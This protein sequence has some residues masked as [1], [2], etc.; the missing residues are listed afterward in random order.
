MLTARMLVAI[1]GLSSAEEAVE[2]VLAA[3]SAAS[4]PFGVRF[5][6]DGRFEGDF[7]DLRQSGGVL[8]HG[9]VL[10]FDERA[11]LR[12][13]QPLLTDETHFLT[14]LGPYGFA[15]KWDGTL[16]ARLRKSSER[17]ALMTGMISA[18][19]EGLPPEPYLP[20]F[21]ENFE[22]DGVLIERG[23]PL[24]CSAAPVRTLAVDPAL[25]FGPTEFLRCADPETD[26]LSIAAYMAGFPVYALDRPALWPL[27][28]APARRLR[29][30]VENALPGTTLARFEQMAGFR[31]EQKRA[32][33][34]TT[35]G[36][37]TVENT[38]AQ[39]LPH[40]LAVSQ[41]ARAILSRTRSGGMPLVVTAFIDLPKPKK[42][43]PVYVLRF[44]FMKG[45][46]NLPILLYTGGGQ[47][48]LLRAGF[49]N[50]WS[51]PDNAVLPKSLLAQGMTPAQHM[52]RSKI[53]LLARAAQR[54]P[55]FTHVA[56]ANADL[57]THPI[58][59][60]A[61]PDFSHLMDD[62]VHLA[63]VNAIP[64]LSFIIA[65][66]SR[67]RLLAREV[68]AITQMD[69][70]MKRGFSEKVLWER[71]VNQ[72]PD[73]FTLHKMPARHLLMHTAFAPELLSAPYRKL[74]NDLPPP[75]RGERKQDK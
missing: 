59:P 16:Y 62:R 20:A 24:V 63:T 14:L 27:V 7:A 51:Y 42:P 39:Q 61:A 4:N 35:W 55:E 22:A 19:S 30:P 12:G 29:R 8:G 66:V 49:P 13:L 64:D 68:N 58:C 48:R 10:F 47:E 11:G 38:Y 73:L 40:A 41:R 53:L 69:A 23:L 60:Q 31:Y 57:M 2:T 5:A 74:L 36:L 33:V 72:Y 43:I 21:A 75:W 9:C 44:G 52:R 71:L 65:P 28:P 56:W 54:H 26:T 25:F 32:G 1:F 17:N 70:E 45:V 18:A 15:E 50:T 3:L 67:L 34:K 6:V 37:F 46:L